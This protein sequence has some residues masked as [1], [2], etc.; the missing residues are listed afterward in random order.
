[1]SERIVN[2]LPNPVF[3]LLI[4]FV[5]DIVTIVI[6]FIVIICVE[7]RRIRKKGK[8]DIEL[9]EKKKNLNKRDTENKDKLSS[10]LSDSISNSFNGSSRNIELS[11]IIPIEEKEEKKMILPKKTKKKKEHLED[12]KDIEIPNKIID[13]SK[14]AETK[15]AYY[16]E[17]MKYAHIDNYVNNICNTE[18]NISNK[19]TFIKEKPS[20]IQNEISEIKAQRENIN[21]KVKKGKN[22]KIRNRI[23]NN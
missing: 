21:L 13:I 2:R 8:E 19:I 12:T 9:I 14:I 7:R 5:G 3:Y 18:N 4:F 17:D 1:M 20:N 16:N 15:Q 22:K 11:S 6:L 23:N 10:V